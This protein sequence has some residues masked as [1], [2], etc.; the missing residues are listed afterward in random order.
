MTGDGW[1]RVDTHV[2]VLDGDVVRRAKARGIDALVYAPHYTRLPA[3]H[4]R[5]ARFS[6]DELLVVPGR[7]VFTGSW[8]DRKHVLAVGLEAPVPDFVTLAGAMREFDRQDAT[9]VVPHPEFLTV[10]LSE[11][12]VRRH[13]STVDCVEVHNPKHWPHHARR[14]REIQRAVGAPPT[15]ASYAHLRGTVGAAWTAFQ[16]AIDDEA[17]LLAALRDGDASRRIARRTGIADRVQAAAE[18]AH[19]GWENSYEKFDRVVLEGLEATHPDQAAYGGRF[20]D[21]AVY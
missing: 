13:R 21:V 15:A 12:D 16:R 1:T 3:I 19:L 20:D 7:E 18:F 2:K 10:G 6:D 4:E 8:R 17:D 14:A 5:A 9:V 11:A